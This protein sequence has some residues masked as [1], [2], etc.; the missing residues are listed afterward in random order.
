MVRNTPQENACSG[1]R[2]TNATINLYVSAFSLRCLY[3]FIWLSFQYCFCL[4]PS[5]FP[6]LPTRPCP[7]P[8]FNTFSASNTLIFGAL[9]LPALDGIASGVEGGSTMASSSSAVAFSSSS[10]SISDGSGEDGIRVAAAG[11]LRG[12]NSELKITNSCPIMK[13]S[14]VGNWQERQINTNYYGASCQDANAEHL[15]E[16]NFLKAP[17]YIYILVPR[18]KAST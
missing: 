9:L 3:G 17:S 8:H 4:Y 1:E 18:I 14:M 13:I 12:G 11:A 7:E 15:S 5:L 10:S 16:S 2:R 6:L